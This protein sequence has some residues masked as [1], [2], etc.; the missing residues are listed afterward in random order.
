[1]DPPHPTAAVA[2]GGSATSLARMAGQVLDAAALARSLGALASEPSD[3]VARRWL[4]DPQ[5]ARLLP[6]GLLILEAMAQRLG[7]PIT[8][9]RGGIREGVVLEAL[10]R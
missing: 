3:A 2:V 1:V 5:R 8:V 6:A 10:P 7:A 4:I 9:G